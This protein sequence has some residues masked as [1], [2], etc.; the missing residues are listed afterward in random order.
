VN[1]STNDIVVDMYPP[2]PYTHEY[3]GYIVPPITMVAAPMRL[4][5][6]K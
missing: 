6:L 5:N 2:V 4:G 1:L 3:W